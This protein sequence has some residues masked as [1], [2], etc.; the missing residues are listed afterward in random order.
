MGRKR[1][2]LLRNKT[3]PHLVVI[4]RAC[5]QIDSEP[6]R[7]PFVAASVRS[8]K[9]AHAAESAEI[10]R[11]TGSEGRRPEESVLPPR[12]ARRGSGFLA[13]RARNDNR[14]TMPLP[15]AS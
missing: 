1:I 7:H 13:L 15:L 11:L 2:D 8:S 9:E 6:P 12:K 3:S 4:L 10:E 5:E 14:A